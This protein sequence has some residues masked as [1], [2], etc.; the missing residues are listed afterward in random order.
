MAKSRAKNPYDSEK[1][2]T[3]EA[4]FERFGIRSPMQVE[5]AESLARKLSWDD[6]NMLGTFLSEM[7]F[8]V[9]APRRK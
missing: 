8:R 2:E 7:S 4:L 9:G 3:I 5:L 1:F 6:I